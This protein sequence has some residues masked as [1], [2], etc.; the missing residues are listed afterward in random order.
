I[1]L[2]T[3]YK[4]REHAR[5]YG[6]GTPPIEKPKKQTKLMVEFK[7]KQ[8]ESF[9]LDKDNVTMS[10]YKI[11]SKTNLPILYLHDNKTSLWKKFQQTFPNGM[12][13]TSF[14]SGL[15]IAHI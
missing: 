9:F 7:K 11:D 4:A 8:F 3:V 2:K 6:A 10:S 12:K 5:L 14:M 13:K 15:Q 1:T